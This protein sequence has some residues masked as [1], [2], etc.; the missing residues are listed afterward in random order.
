LK[1]LRFTDKMQEVLAKI[2]PNVLSFREKLHRYPELGYEEHITTDL[3]VNKLV[4]IGIYKIETKYSKTGVVG[5]IEADKAQGTIAI[6]AD[7][8][9]LPLKENTCATFASENEGTMHACG[10]DVHTSIVIGVA[11]LLQHFRDKLNVNVKLI[12]Q[13]AEECSPEGGAKALIANGV[14]HDV[15]VIVGLHVWPSLP[16]GTVGVVKGSAMAASD[17]LK[18]TVFGRGAHAAEPQNGIDAIMIATQ[19]VNAINSFKARNIDPFE[20]VVLSLGTINSRGRYNIICSQVDIEGTI[21]T[22][23]EDIRCFIDKKLVEIVVN[24]SEAL[25]GS[26]VVNILRGYGILK[27]DD[28]LTDRFTE[29]TKSLLGDDRVLSNVK[30]SMISEDFAFY[31]M[32]V[33]ATYFFL[34]CES[35]HPLHSSQF[36]PNEGCIEIGIKV[37]TNLVLNDL[38]GIDEKQSQAC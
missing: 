22:L 6:R 14:L 25:G 24:A 37:L 11:E 5:V 10:H 19:V 2:L 21:R 18:I 3:I 34:G 20:P 38:L 28:K 12:F 33:P 17:K 26:A 30:P 4:E 31:A 35:L 15:D 29:L 16:V 32:Q 8:D 23:N 9:A 36:L 1:Q 7:I 27:N 13:P